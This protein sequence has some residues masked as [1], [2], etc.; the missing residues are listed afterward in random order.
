MTKGHNHRDQSSAPVLA[1]ADNISVSEEFDRYSNVY[2][3]AVNE[4]LAFSGLT[5]DFF[6]KVKAAYFIDIL[7]AR[8]GDAA[9]LDVLDVGCGVGIYHGLIG[10][11]VKSLHGVDISPASIERAKA[12]NL[13]T[14]YHHY[15]GVTL[16]F[17]LP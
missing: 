4:S 8:L 10:P 16:P 9:T 1:D 12:D 7:N 13:N 11:K 15:D 2:A 3:D 17:E 5:V 6:T 14:H